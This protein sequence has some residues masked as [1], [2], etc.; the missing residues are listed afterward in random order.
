[1]VGWLPIAAKEFAET[2]S[3]K[4]IRS[5]IKELA[6]EALMWSKGS[7][8]RLQNEAHVANMKFALALKKGD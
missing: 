1:M 2:F 3:E 6:E 7:E 8:N 5:A 4:E